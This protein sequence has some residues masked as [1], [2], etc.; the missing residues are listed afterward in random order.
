MERGDKE[1]TQGGIDRAGKKKTG[2]CK[3]ESGRCESVWRGQEMFRAERECET[4]R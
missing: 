4:M 3:T 1:R 2:E